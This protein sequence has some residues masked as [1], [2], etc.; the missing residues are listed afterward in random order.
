MKKITFLML[1]LNYGGLERQTVSLINGL[2]NLGYNVEI[3]CVYDILGKSFYKLDD[4]VNI[5]YLTK[6]FP[7]KMKLLN[8]IK[9]F[10]L[11][12]AF[13]EC[14]I[15][16]K[17][18]YNK[19]TTL[20]KVIANLDTD[21][22]ISTRPEFSK[23]IKRN[24]TFNISVEHSFINNK[25]YFK[26]IN[27]CFKNINKVI[28]MTNKAKDIYNEDL[29]NKYDIKSGLEIKCIPNII[30]ENNDKVYSAL[31]NKQIIAVG[32][33][34]DIKRYDVLLDIFKKFNL[35][36]NDY[37]LKIIGEGSKKESL[38]KQ[39][40][41]LDLEGKVFLTGKLTFDEINKELIKSDV[42]CLT[43]SSESFSL[44]LC[45]ALNFG[46]PVISFDIDVGPR[47]IITNNVDGILVEDNN[48]DEY[49]LKLCE[50]IEDNEKLITMGNSAKENVKRYY[51]ENIIKL[52]SNIFENGDK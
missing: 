32:R 48:I 7:D 20:K 12:S 42:F 9:Y 47:E 43:S 25:K 5:T 36:H 51:S 13:K 34:E 39:I 4:K 37:T 27:N 50:L 18:L 49:I 41:E 35:K 19:Y 28:V 30:D 10:K 44:V 46:V 2:C 16:L 22:I 26:Y 29:I 21:I 23:L 24:D 52:W 45:E 14:N 3:I 17:C 15:S 38:E 11:I 1:H 6:G 40:L 31:N 8:N 33:L